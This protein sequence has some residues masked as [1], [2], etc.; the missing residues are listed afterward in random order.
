M[1]AAREGKANIRDRNV[2]TRE[3]HSFSALSNG[4]SFFFMRPISSLSFC[5]FAS[6]KRA[7]DLSRKSRY[8]DKDFDCTLSDL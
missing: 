1:S 6:A 5:A 2:E 4:T 7:S 3:A 8:S